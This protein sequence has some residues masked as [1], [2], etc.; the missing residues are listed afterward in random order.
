MCRA[1]I[2]LGRPIPLDNLLFQPESSLVNQ[3]LLPQKLNLLNLA[4]FGMMA[5]DS[6]SH[7]PDRPFRYAISAL[8]IFDRNLRALAEK[9]TPECVI[10]HVR[11]VAYSAT[12]QVS[13]LNTHPFCFDGYP[14]ALAHNGDLY[15]VEDMKRDLLSFIKPEIARHISGSTD[16]EWIYALIL[17][18]LADPRA[19]PDGPELVDAVR[20][21]L[22]IIRDIRAKN[23][24]EISS[25]VNLFIA[26][27]RNVLGVR[28]C[29]D[30]GC[31]LSESPE[32]VHEANLSFLSLWYTTGR[33]FGLHEGEWK[34]IGG[35]ETADSLLIASEPLTHDTTTWL[36]VPE[37]SAVFGSLL[38]A[39]P[40]IEVHPLDL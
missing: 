40:T 6:R 29:F 39:K 3:A 7:R 25:S 30:F 22:A 27:G 11:G 37:Y 23:S 5:W 32:R 1:L 15:R 16:S 21:A 2:Y 26:T 28:Y 9:L 8:P 38:G 4:G 31:Y 10:A 35:E 33:D 17:S 36:E 13:E 14:V 20:R 12:S 18:Q 34:M 19:S 24:I